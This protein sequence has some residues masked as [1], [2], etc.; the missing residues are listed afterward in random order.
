MAPLERERL[1]ALVGDQHEVPLDG[2][3]RDL[4]ER[5]AREDG[6]RRVV[7]A[8]EEDHLRPRRHGGA[9][10]VGVEVEAGAL[11]RRD[12][13]GHAADEP[14]LLRVGHPERARHEHLVAGVQERDDHVVKRVLGAA[15]DEDLLGGVVEALV[16]LELGADGRAQLGDAADLRVLRLPAAHRLDRRLLDP[17]GRVEVGLPGAEG[18]HVDAPGAERLSLGL[19][20]ECRRGG[21]G[22][23]AVSE[24][25]RAPSA[26]S[27]RVTWGGT[28]PPTASRRSAAR[29]RRPRSRSWRPP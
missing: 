10:P 5:R 16:A 23:Q 21:K 18:D 13:H 7:R 20:G 29:A 1:V 11:L 14:D 8:V 24:H 28:S 27:R 19:D 3:A 9:H 2:E 4:R 17:L 15:R 26:V 12:R 25:G 22:L 6:A